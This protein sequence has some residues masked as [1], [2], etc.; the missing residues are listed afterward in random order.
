VGSAL[1]ALVGFGVGGGVCFEAEFA[2]DDGVGLDGG[3]FDELG[4]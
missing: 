2:D 4:D 3:V 1:A